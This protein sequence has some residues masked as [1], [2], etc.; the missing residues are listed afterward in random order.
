MSDLLS[1]EIDAFVDRVRDHWE[2]P[3]LAL[4]VLQKAEPVHVRAY[5]VRDI[6]SGRRVG[7]DTRFAIASCS[8]SFTATVAAVLCDERRLSW[9][10]PVRCYLPEFRLYDPWV[11]ERVTLRDLFGCRV[12]LSQAALAESSSD[13]GRAEVLRRAWSISPAAS[14]RDHFCYSNMGF[15]AGAAALEVAAGTTFEHLIEDRIFRPLQMTTGTVADRPWEGADNIAMPHYRVDGRIRTVK[16]IPLDNMMGAAS[17]TLSVSDAVPWMRLHLT[18]GRHG[19]D[20]LVS[21][22]TLAETHRLQS[23]A[24]DRSFF[25]GYGMGWLVGGVDTKRSLYH[26][27]AIRGAL[28]AV[29]LIPDEGYG[30]FVAVNSSEDLRYVRAI[31]RFVRQ[32]IVGQSSGDLIKHVEAEIARRSVEGQDR[33]AAE[34]EVEAPPWRWHLEQFAGIYRHP[35]LGVMR[36]ESSGDELLWIRLDH[37]SSLDGPLVRYAD[38]FFE[39]QGDEDAFDRQLSPHTPLGSAPSIRFKVEDGRIVGL[40]WRGMWFGDVSFEREPIPD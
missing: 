12:G 23:L 13:W 7:V 36:L 17:I 18:E 19:A 15:I 20:T 6:D 9:D 31:S 32:M 29:H 8:K 10:D 3:G 35:G 2:I 39:Y 4:A 30:C 11:T 27:G 1:S 21:A 5:G 22:A 37:A 33:L 38:T 16:P 34:R 14:F 28:A 24:R 26:E 40:H 25:E